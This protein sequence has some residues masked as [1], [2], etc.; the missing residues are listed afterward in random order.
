MRGNIR[1]MRRWARGTLNHYLNPLH[2]YCRLADCG[3]NIALARRI[4]MSYEAF[5]RRL[6]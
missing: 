1:N 4:S 2:V 5:Y 3:L 6:W